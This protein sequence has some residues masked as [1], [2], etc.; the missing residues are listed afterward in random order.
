MAK[1][2]KP[3]ANPVVAALLT[4]LVLGTGHWLINGQQKKWI[5]IL[6]A[7]L[8][9]SILCC[10]PGTVIAILSIIDAY[11]TAVKLKSGKEI[12][13]NEYSMPLLFKIVKI[14]H[15]DAVLVE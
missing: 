9:G 5:M 2:S 11:K 7:T 10:L 12:D 1:I 13:E 6:V 15:K 3:G 14:I 4:W 8:I